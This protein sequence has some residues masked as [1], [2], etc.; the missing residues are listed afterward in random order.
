MQIAKQEVPRLGL[1]VHLNLTYGR[2]LS[3]PQKHDTLIDSEGYLRAKEIYFTNPEAIDIDEV[4]YE[5]RAQIEA[6]LASGATLD[7]LDSHH[8]IALSSHEI[9]ELFIKCAQDYDCPVRFPNPVDMPDNALLDV[10]PNVPIDF[11][12]GSG[13][14]MLSEA[15]IRHPDHFLASF[16]AF[17]VNLKHLIHILESLPD[18]VSELMCHPGHVDDE[19]RSQSGYANEREQELRLLFHPA[20]IRCVA[21]SGITLTTFRQA[22]QCG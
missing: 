17:G 18:G 1:G 15:G 13:S 10:L 8:H 9:W 11:V 6:F 19:L 16:F 7:H 3:A 14:H 12:R 4:E 21:E 2:P 5:W 22:W 20:V